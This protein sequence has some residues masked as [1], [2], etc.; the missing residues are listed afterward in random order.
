[1]DPNRAPTIEELD[2]ASMYA[3]SKLCVDIPSQFQTGL[4]Y[5]DDKMKKCR[6]SKG[7]CSPSMQNPISL[8]SFS[9]NGSI[10]DW[11]KLGASDNLKKFWSIY[12]PEH[13]VYKVV[14][15]S[16]ESVCARAN[17]KLQQFCEFPN[18]RTSKD[19]DAFGGLTG[20]GYDRVPPFK[21]LVQN[22]KETCLIGKDY[23][24]AKGMNWNGEEC[25]VNTYQKVMEFLLSKYL[26]VEMRKAGLS[27]L[28]TI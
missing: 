9:V 19:D 13:L 27:P 17:F 2:A 7:G 21:Y 26:M 16:K 12:P 24:D 15:G 18:Q 28:S 6:I 23:C 11:K 20:K 8:Y 14:S 22:G 3:R 5:W 10:L 1:M 25:Y 4:T